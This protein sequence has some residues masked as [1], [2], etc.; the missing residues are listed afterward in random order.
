MES[1]TSYGDIDLQQQVEAL[2][3]YVDLL[4]NYTLNLKDAMIMLLDI[5]D[6]RKALGEKTTKVLRNNLANGRRGKTMQIK[7]TSVLD[8]LPDE[9]KKIYISG[10]GFVAQAYYHAGMYWQD[11]NRPTER[12]SLASVSN[13]AEVD[14][15]QE[16]VDHVADKA[17]EHER[18]GLA[19]IPTE[20]LEQMAE[21][22][23]EGR[24]AIEGERYAAYRGYLAGYCEAVEAM[25]TK[26]EKK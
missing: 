9:G 25:S 22:Y 18:H 24:W 11:A 1:E 4:Q 6:I 2:Q 15:V 13:W 12:F 23:V 5:P 8:A 14:H 7:W 21:E 10:E 3:S 16:V 20:L 17:M 26:V 19:Y